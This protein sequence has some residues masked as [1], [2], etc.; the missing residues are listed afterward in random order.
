MKPTLIQILKV[1]ITMILCACILYIGHNN[2]NRFNM[3]RG[4]N[5]RNEKIKDSLLWQSSKTDSLLLKLIGQ[6]EMLFQLNLDVLKTENNE[7]KQINLN[8]VKLLRRIHNLSVERNA[9]SDSLLKTL[10]QGIVYKNNV[11]NTK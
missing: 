7:L 2:N 6:N 11:C 5:L 8:M 9:I 10:K 4:E 3:D 1:I